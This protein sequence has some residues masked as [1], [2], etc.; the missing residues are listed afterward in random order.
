LNPDEG[1]DWFFF[2]SL[3]EGELAGTVELELEVEMPH[4][5]TLQ[6]LSSPC[7]V[8]R[9]TGRCPL[10]NATESNDSNFLVIVV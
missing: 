4:L 9:I 7:P 1:C 2:L 6:T 8:S 3:F 5:T 10:L